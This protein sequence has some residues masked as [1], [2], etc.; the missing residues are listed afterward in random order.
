M[1][2][3]PVILP[4]FAMIPRDDNNNN[5]N[6]NNKHPPQEGIEPRVPLAVVVRGE[7]APLGSARLVEGKVAVD[8]LVDGSHVYTITG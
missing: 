4:L 5:N 6:N 7:A 8:G 3:W 1:D 2:R